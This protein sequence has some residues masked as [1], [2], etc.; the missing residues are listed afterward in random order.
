VTIEQCIAQCAS[1]SPSSLSLKCNTLTTLADTAAQQ[2]NTAA[3]AATLNA[4]KAFN[5][6]HECKV[7][8]NHEHAVTATLAAEK[9][10]SL[11][12]MLDIAVIAAENQEVATETLEKIVERV[13]LY[14]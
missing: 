9:Q 2:H 14:C 8:V 6:Y 3:L 5:S 11:Q 7:N 13:L 1:S 10:P 4:I 12:E